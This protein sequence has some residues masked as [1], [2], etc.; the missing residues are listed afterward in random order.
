MFGGLRD[1][2][3]TPPPL[4]SPSFFGVRFIFAR[5]WPR[6]NREA[7]ARHPVVSMLL[8]PDSK[9]VVIAGKSAGNG[10]NQL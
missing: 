8:W 3:R 2:R 6:P 5:P 4:P 7:T 9:G 10:L 1:I